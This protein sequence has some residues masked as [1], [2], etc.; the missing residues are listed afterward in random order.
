MIRSMSECTYV[1]TPCHPAPAFGR[2]PPPA[3][4]TYDAY[5]VDTAAPAG[6]ARQTN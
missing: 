6:V 4:R 5:G 3:A 2:R 1:R